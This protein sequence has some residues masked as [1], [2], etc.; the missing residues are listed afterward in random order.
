M[1][2]M[3]NRIDQASCKR[4]LRKEAACLAL[5]LPL[6]VLCVA[7]TIGSDFHIT[8]YPQR[9]HG[10]ASAGAFYLLRPN[11]GRVPPATKKQQTK[12]RFKSD[13]ITRRY[14]NLWE[15]EERFS[16]VESEDEEE[17]A[18]KVEK[19]EGKVGGALVHEDVWEVANLGFVVDFEFDSKWKLDEEQPGDAVSFKWVRQQSNW[20]YAIAMLGQ[21]AKQEGVE[22]TKEVVDA[23]KD[24]VGKETTPGDV[25]HEVV[26]RESKRPRTTT[27]T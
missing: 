9:F 12:I 24:K 22:V 16:N 15:L 5:L 1:R 18:M 19:I 3:K 20:P 4:L 11:I 17:E 13:I 10:G 2:M 6:A 26:S 14:D 23:I 25:I 7:V 27:V 21:L 8:G